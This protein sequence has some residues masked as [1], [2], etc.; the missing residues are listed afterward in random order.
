[1]AQ[2]TKFGPQDA[3]TS[4]WA[5]AELGVRDPALARPLLVACVSQSSKFNTHGAAYSLLAAAELNVFDTD[6]IKPLLAACVSRSATF[7]AHEAFTSLKAAAMIKSKDTAAID[8]LIRACVSHV[9]EVTLVQAVSAMRACRQLRTLNS[10]CLLEP[11]IPL[12]VAQVT[13]LHAADANLVLDTALLLNISDPAVL[14][15]LQAAAH[16]TSLGSSSGVS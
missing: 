9:R 2:S 7:N 14:G 10:R 11:L 4:A 1:V 16:P 13:D 12:C 8:A 6:I 15:A 3:A 5:A